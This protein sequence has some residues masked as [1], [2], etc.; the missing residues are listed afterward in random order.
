MFGSLVLLAHGIIYFIV[1]GSIFRARQ[2]IGV[3]VFFCLL[4]TMHF[5]ETYLAATFFIE[6]PFG[7]ISPGSTVMFTASSPFSCCFTSRKTPR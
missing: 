7:L 1:M 3:G 4:G 2:S 6:L 5:L